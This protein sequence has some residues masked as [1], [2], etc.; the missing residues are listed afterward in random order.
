MSEH[1]IT[2]FFRE[3]TGRQKLIDPHHSEAQVVL[4]S[5]E[6]I[7]KNSASPP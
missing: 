1:L 5:P 3:A 4:L 2:K 6:T 7:S